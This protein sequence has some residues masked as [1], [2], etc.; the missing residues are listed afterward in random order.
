M[1]RTAIAD[2]LEQL[3][4]FADLSA[5]PRAFNGPWGTAELR[6]LPTDFF[7]AEASGLHPAGHGE[8]LLLRVRKIGQNTRWV[9]KRLA[10]LADVPYRAVSYAGMKD[11][12]AVTEQWFG[13]H[14]PGKAD[15]EWKIGPDE[16][17]E[18]LE[19]VRHDRKLRTGQLSYNRFRLQLRNCQ[20]TDRSELEQCLRDV[21]ASGVP[22]YFGPQRFGHL[23][24]NLFLLQNP[25]DLRRLDR[26]DRAFALSA[27]RGALFN[28]Y[29]ATR[30]RAHTW[31]TM[32]QGDVQIS[33][34]PRG[35]AEEDHSVFIAERLSAGLLWGKQAMLADPDTNGEREFYQQFPQITALLEAAGSQASRRV[36]CT[37]VGALDWHWEGEQL[38]LEFA[39][40][41]GSYATA[42]LNELLEVR[43]MAA[44]ESAL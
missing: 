4:C 19:A 20:I 12:H 5:L 35:V 16:G 27:L 38:V 15:P 36:L 41:P 18:I 31:R 37:R 8:H 30:V 11:R 22:N 13:I 26:D 28:G 33:D 6:S 1:T 3:R 2:E 17:F 24:A 25:G 10:A 29:L 34:R 44:F 7:V 14:L 39:L 43:D 23:A 21:A 9:A 40:G 32:E 42:V